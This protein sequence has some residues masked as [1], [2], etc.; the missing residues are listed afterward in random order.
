MKL[1]RHVACVEEQRNASGLRILLVEEYEK[2]HL[3]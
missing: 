3:G 1:V 2:I